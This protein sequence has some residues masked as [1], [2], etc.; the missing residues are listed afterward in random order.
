[1]KKSFWKKSFAIA[2]SA[3]IA[4]SASLTGCSQTG[5]TGTSGASGGSSTAETTGGG[6]KTQMTFTCLIGGSNQ[7]Y[8]DLLTPIIEEFNANNTYNV[9]FKQEGYVNEQYKTKLTTLMAS[10]AQPDVFYTWESGF[11]KPFVEGGKVYPIGDK[12]E[13]DEE[14][15]SRFPDKSVFGP[16]TYSD[17]KIYAMPNSRQI[18]IISYNKKMFAD[19]GVEV[20]KT[21]DE[22]MQVC[23]A[24]KAKGYT[25][26]AIPCK[27]AW[28]GGQFMQQLANGVGGDDLYN[29]ICNGETTWDD[30]RFIEAGNLLADIVNKGY[31]TSDYLGMSP[32]EAFDALN[33]GRLA[34]FYHITSGMNVLE[35]PENPAY[36]D[37]GFF[38]LPPKNPENAGLNV[39]SLGQCFA[40]S[41]QAKNI[42]ASCEL[43]KTFSGE[44][45]QKGLA[46]EM[47]DVIVTN[48]E[49]DESKLPPLAQEVLPLYDEITTYTPW[50]D[51][52]FG[53]GEG[54]EFNNA[55]VAIM[56]GEDSAEAMKNLQQFAIDN[57]TR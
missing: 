46:E 38:R 34:M 8:A 22:F 54:V 53:A 57:A 30:E 4:A 40:V 50:F 11:L 48:T 35:N 41:S 3:M 47:G 37:L 55:S 9:E 32:N 31:L 39:G 45:F 21:L 27:E 33:M 12:L 42:D 29:Q 51:R 28:Y 36:E 19:A 15:N 26:L 16:V 52:I 14:W 17:G 24:L 13:A 43:V 56:A 25:P 23:E 10:N 1:M 5:T 7:A 6:E 20:P 44:K 2:L 49:F 18:C